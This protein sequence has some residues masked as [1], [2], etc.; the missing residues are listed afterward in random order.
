MGEIDYLPE[1]NHRIQVVGSLSEFFNAS[2]QAVQDENFCGKNLIVFP[3]KLPGDFNGLA[4]HLARE[5]RVSSDFST[6]SIHDLNRLQEKGG[7]TPETG[8][9]LACIRRD[10]EDIINTLWISSRR[11]VGNYTDLRI[12]RRYEN[13]ASSVRWFHKDG[14]SRICCC[15]NDPVTQ[16]GRNEDFT[17]SEGRYHPTSINVKLF[18]ARAGDL[19]C[20]FGGTGTGDDKPYYIHRGPDSYWSRPRLMLVADLRL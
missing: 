8:E 10:A 5:F 12:I 3:R 11:S 9:A 14:V 19:T 15:Y 7:L 2:A 18:S 17:Y 13:T 16:G 20:H 6:L 1:D 4:R